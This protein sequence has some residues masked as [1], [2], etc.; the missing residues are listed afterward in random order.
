M[1]THL[2]GLLWGYVS[3]TS[4]VLDECVALLRQWHPSVDTTLPFGSPLSK[5]CFIHQVASRT[6]ERYLSKYDTF[7][8]PHSLL[9]FG[10]CQ[11]LTR[12]FNDLAP[13]VWFH[14]LT[15][16]DTESKTFVLTHARQTLLQHYLSRPEMVTQGMAWTQPH[17]H[18]LQLL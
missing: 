7:C 16:Y 8:E 6:I 17:A 10:L 1:F 2:L 14:L 4:A 5:V 9:P 3:P 15:Y 11:L 18:L 13:L 12:C